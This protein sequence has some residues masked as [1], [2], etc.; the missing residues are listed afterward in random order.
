M[1]VG[2]PLE[3]LTDSW[4]DALPASGHGRRRM[5]EI[6]PFE[7][8]AMKTIIIDDGNRDSMKMPCELVVTHVLPNARGAIARELVEKHGM[9][10]TQVAKLFGVT[11]AAVSQYIKGMRGGNNLIDKSAYKKDF[12]EMISRTAASIASGTDVTE[13]LCGICAFVKQCGLLRALYVYEGYDGELA[14]CMDCPR[15]EIIIPD[16]V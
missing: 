3:G 15:N 13:A 8:T 2:H 9:T 12:D 4:T 11:S 6:R 7:L 5:P 10:Q 16:A 1:G 14:A